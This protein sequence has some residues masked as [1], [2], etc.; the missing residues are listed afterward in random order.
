MT[1]ERGLP[2]FGLDAFDCPHCGAFAHQRWSPNVQAFA[3]DRQT[4]LRF[5]AVSE[6]ARCREFA[7]WR[8]SAMIYPDKLTSPPMNLDMP[9]SAR[10]DYEEAASVLTRSPRAS[11]ALLRLAIQKICDQLVPGAVD[12]NQKIAQLVKQGLRVEIQQALDAVRVVGNNAV[13]PG[14]MNLQDDHET[15]GTLFDLT[16]L[17]IEDRI[18]QPKKIATLYD[19]LPQAA[20][21]AIKKRDQNAAP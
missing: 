11:A 10:A 4:T 17:I 2:Q 12:L 20:K 13:H 14:E 5:L 16:N 7:L 18:S 6:C 3:L 19:K 21:K 15:C 9:E 8:H 1:G